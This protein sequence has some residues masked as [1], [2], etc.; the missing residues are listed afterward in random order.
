MPELDY[1]QIWAL[2]MVFVVGPIAAAIWQDF[3]HSDNWK[4]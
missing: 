4:D 1:I 3:T 2:L